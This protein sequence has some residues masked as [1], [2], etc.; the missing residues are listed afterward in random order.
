MGSEVILS[1]DLWTSAGARELRERKINA[2]TGCLQ[3]RAESAVLERPL[4]VYL[5]RGVRVTSSC[6][7]QC[8]ETETTSPASLVFVDII[9]F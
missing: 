2:T 8:N 5:H 7:V 4:T 9:D 3:W 6:S 1:A